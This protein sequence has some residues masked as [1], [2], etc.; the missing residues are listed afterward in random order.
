MCVRML[1]VCTHSSLTSFAAASAL[2]DVFMPNEE[3]VQVGQCLQGAVFLRQH[4]LI[5]AVDLVVT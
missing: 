3:A 2:G 5:L 4:L 1:A